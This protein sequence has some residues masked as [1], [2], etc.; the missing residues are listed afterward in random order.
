[1]VPPYPSE[2]Y[3]YLGHTTEDFPIAEYS[4]DT[5]ISLPPYEGMTDEEIDYVIEVI[6]RFE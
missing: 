3:G 2:A 5:V 4:A 6:N 1:M